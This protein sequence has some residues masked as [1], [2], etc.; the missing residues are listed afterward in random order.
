MT[1]D[2]L[3]PVPETLLPADPAQ[4]LL[5]AGDSAHEVAA[6]H[7]TSSAAWA[8]LA[9]DALADGRVIEGYAFARVGYHRGLDLLRRNGWRGHGPVP[10]EHAPNRG[11][12]R[13]LHH[14]AVAAELIGEADEAH[15]CR[16]FLHE[17]S[18]TAAEVLR[19]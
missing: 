10:W 8:A 13:C 7:P 19:G 6:S 15:R 11:W 1:Q 12:L 4:G 9:Q 2:L 3:N 14:L 18:R 5:D 17:S 16:E